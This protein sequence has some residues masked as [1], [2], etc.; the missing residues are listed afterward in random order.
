MTEQ[1]VHASALKKEIKER[2]KRVSRTDQSPLRPMGMA[3]RVQQRRS[4]DRTKMST[5]KNIA[6]K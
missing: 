5:K 3:G 6:R 2:R 4:V 1:R